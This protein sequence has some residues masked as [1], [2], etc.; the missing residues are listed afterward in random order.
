MK[1]R[2]LIKLLESHGWF[3]Y[4]VG[5]GDHMVCRHREY[6]STDPFSAVQSY[7]Q[8]GYAGGAWNGPGIDSSAAAGNSAYAL[9]CVDGASGI[10][11]GLSSGQI[12]IKYTLYGDVNLDGEVSGTDFGI[13]A[14]HFGKS[15]TGGWEEGDFTY[16]GKVNATD[17][18]LLAANFGK[19]ASGADITLPASDWAA[20]DAFAAAHGLLADVPEPASASSLFFAGILLTRRRCRGTKIKINHPRVR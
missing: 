16:A 20:L 13:V 8:S 19:T 10:V 5:K 14:A 3:F 18:G 2:D 9:G 17:F 12:E 15:V 7:L 11:A 6:G 1:Y 4:R